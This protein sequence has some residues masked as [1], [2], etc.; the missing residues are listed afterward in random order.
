ML[1]EVAEALLEPPAPAL[2]LGAAGGLVALKRRRLGLGLIAAAGVL[3]YVFC[4]PWL[5]GMLLW[6]LQRDVALTP[7]DSGDPLPQ[8]QA[9][10]VLSAG[11]NPAG[12]EWGHAT[13][14]A[15]SL[16]RVRYAAALARRTGLPLL[17]SGG[18]PRRGERPL[19]EM[20]R[21]V[22]ERDF[23]LEVR[24]VEGASA[25]T[26]ENASESVRLL[27]AA[28]IERAFLVTH[29]WHMPRA[30]RA[31]EACGFSVIPAP[32]AFRIRPRLEPGAFWPTAR[33]LREFTWATHELL[34]SLWYH[35]S[36]APE[37]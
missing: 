33:A 26:R 12:A 35:I 20:L 9:I 21:E 31:F 19:A 1:S 22:L 5:A 4:C 30:R 24:W 34:G 2:L 28:G 14:D 18:V 25:N 11:W 37:S 36:P 13:V 6:S 15:L 7:E 8:A 32:T 10:V 16:E 23:G 29:A 17:A 3:L 27:R